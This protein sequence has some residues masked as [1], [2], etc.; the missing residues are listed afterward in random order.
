MP[1]LSVVVPVYNEIRTIPEILRRIKRVE[2][3][4]EIIVVDDGSTDGTREILKAMNDPALRIIFH[5]RNRGKGAA[6]RTGIQVARGDIVIIQDADLEYN[7]AEYPRLIKP[8]LEGN[9]DVVYGSRFMGASEHRVLFFWHYVGNKLLTLLSNMFT[10]L[11]LSDI[12]TGYKVFRRELIQSL[13][14]EE[15]RF[16]FEPEVT[17]KI[18]KKRCR[19][20]E[21]GISYYGRTYEEGKK[22]KLKDGLRALW[23]IIKYKIKA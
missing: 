3:D 2:I 1:L 11:N 7:P 18:A 21:V 4:K 13:R 5:E 12:E 17:A 6:L 15:Q 9:A 20:Y 22:I 23:C 19:I 14:L 16:G 10:D 8:I